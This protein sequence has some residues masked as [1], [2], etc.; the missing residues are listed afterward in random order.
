MN[1]TQIQKALHQAHVYLQQEERAKAIAILKRIIQIQPDEAEAWWLLANAVDDVEQ[2]RIALKRA[3]TFNPDH[4]LARA[5]YAKLETP[6]TPQKQRAKA[7]HYLW[8][9]ALLVIGVLVAIGIV[10]Y[11]GFR[12]GADEGAPTAI[13][14]VVIVES[15]G[16]TTTPLPTIARPTLPPLATAT[17][18]IIVTYPTHTPRPTLALPPTRT[19][20]VITPRATINREAIG[21][22][23]SGV[24]VP[25]ETPP[26]ALEIPPPVGDDY[27][28]GFDGNMNEFTQDGGYYRF[29]EFPVLFYQG[30][31][32]NAGFQYYIEDAL[33]QIGRVVPIER[34]D[35]PEEADLFLEF[36]P[37][38]EL[39]GLCNATNEVEGCGALFYDTDLYSRTGKVDYTGFAAI[40]SDTTI[41]EVV[42]LHELIHA[43]GVLVHSND[44]RDIMYYR[45]TEGFVSARMTTRDYN[46][47]RRLYNARAFGETE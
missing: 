28:Y 11:V 6:L 25:T 37:R 9:D 46:T 21:V 19:P 15:G 34:T 43:V 24:S 10:I 32:P 29:Y 3:L 14:S 22:G 4:A 16:E 35:N 39:Q 18:T 36:L 5:A 13:P 26:I 30:P 1:N 20:F 12:L 33:A 2:K 27:W 7:N 40:A 45:Y 38:I 41:P 31:L 17:P 23:I 8:L 47:L 44:T 42:I